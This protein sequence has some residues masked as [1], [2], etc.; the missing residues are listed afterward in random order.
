[1]KILY[2]ISD[3]GYNKLKPNY[4]TKKG[5][6]LHFLKIFKGYDI[7]VFAD[8]V[9]EDTYDFLQKHTKIT[10]KHIVFIQYLTATN[11]QYN[12]TFLT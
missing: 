1:M 12:N 7:Y 11:K 6:L 2:R 10:K 8:N 9:S 5:V 3:S 4:V